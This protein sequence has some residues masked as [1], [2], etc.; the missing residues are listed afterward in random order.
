MTTRTALITGAGRGIG[1]AIS[2]ALAADIK[3]LVIHYGSNPA[4]A[5]ALVAQLVAR[6]VDAIALGA[7]ISE[8]EQVI[9]LFDAIEAR[10]G[11]VDVVVQNAGVNSEGLNHVVDLSI[12]EYDRL[13][14]INNRGAFL[15]MRE[16]ARRVRR[17]GR[18]IALST[19]LNRIHSVGFAGYATSKGVIDHLVPILA[20]EIAHKGITVN[21]VAPS[22]V[23]TKLFRAG[24]TDQQIAAIKA[25][26]PM[27]RVGLPEDIAPMIRFLASPES[28]WISGQVIGA[29]GA[30]A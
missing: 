12:E 7:D 15:V 11:G 5:E 30:L 10:F 28:Q 9:L 3:Q 20:K 25:A 6:G 19:T 16:A 29:N 2:S 21:A 8:E 13:H 26:Q 23:D 17:D 27:G 24:K 14:A 1:A 4:P 18:I 22:A